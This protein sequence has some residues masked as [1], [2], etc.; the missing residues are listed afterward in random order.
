MRQVLY[1]MGILG[2][3]LSVTPLIG[4][5]HAMNPAILPTALGLTT[6]IFG[7]AS[8]A[9]YNMPKGSL[10][11]YGRVL[12]GSL[13][14]LIGLQLVGLGSLYFV[15]PNPF[16]H[17][18]LNGSTYISAALFTAFVAYDTHLAIRM[19]EQKMPDNLGLAANFVLDFWNIFVSLLHIFGNQQK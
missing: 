4:M 15:G 2:L 9:A 19:Y 12:G 10:L 17:M 1:G 7:G 13:I 16:A 11:S 14:G 3:G 6:A 18:L 8:F 5:V